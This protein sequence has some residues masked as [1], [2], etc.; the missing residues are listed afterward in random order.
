MKA[1]K[2]EKDMMINEQIEEMSNEIISLSNTIRVVEQ[3]MKSHDVSFLKVSKT[4]STPNLNQKTITTTLLELRI[5]L[6]FCFQNYKETIR[7]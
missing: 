5:P 2:E 6:P 1:E 7:R 4:I 3:E